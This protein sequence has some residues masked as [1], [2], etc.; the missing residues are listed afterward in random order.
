[1]VKIEYTASSLGAPPRQF[2][3]AAEGIADLVLGV[4]ANTPARFTLTQIAEMPF[5]GNNGA[6]LS[7]AYWRVHEKLLAPANEHKGV[8]VLALWG[9]G[10]GVVAN[11]IRPVTKAD[12]MKGMK[13]RVAGGLMV[14]IAST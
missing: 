5:L 8:K 10:P 6:A 9:H 3:L 14:D 7:A 12:D 11:S 1:R 13:I 2:D 4:H